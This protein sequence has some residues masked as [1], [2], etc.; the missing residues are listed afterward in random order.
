MAAKSSG[1]SIMQR[2]AHRNEKSDGRSSAKSEASKEQCGRK[3]RRRR[4]ADAARDTR[5][6][7]NSICA[8]P[9]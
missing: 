2:C 8:K 7:G 4:W 3:Q 9:D 1:A 6:V 5:A